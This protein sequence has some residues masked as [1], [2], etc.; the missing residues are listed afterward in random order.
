MG[1]HIA[2]FFTVGGCP[3][4]SHCSCNRDDFFVR[5]NAIAHEKLG[6]LVVDRSGIIDQQQQFPIIQCILKALIRIFI[7]AIAFENR[8][9][10]FLVQ[11]NRK[12]FHDFVPQ[13]V[14]L[15]VLTGYDDLHRSLFRDVIAL[16][17]AGDDQQ[18]LRRV[19]FMLDQMRDFIDQ[20]FL[21]SKS[22][23]DSLVH[24]DSSRY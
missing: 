11:I 14:F 8:F 5:Q 21:V 23:F 3:I 1:R 18:L 19:A 15:T 10:L 2:D 22:T 16:A 12:E 9:F 17:V 24:F 4:R 13:G 6:M 20:H 7:Y